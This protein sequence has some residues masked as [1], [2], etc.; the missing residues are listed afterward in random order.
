MAGNP[1]EERSDSLA[2]WGLDHHGQLNYLQLVPAGGSFPRSMAINK[3]GNLAV[4]GLQLSER[5]V[6]LERDVATGK[7]RGVVASIHQAGNVTSIVWD[8]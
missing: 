4:V 7:F 1:F 6:V 5:L 2:T 3:A 8:E